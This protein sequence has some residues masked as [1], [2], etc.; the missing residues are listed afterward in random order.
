MNKNTL[1]ATLIGTTVTISDGT[2]FEAASQEDASRELHERGYQRVAGWMFGGG[3]SVVASVV[4]NRTPGE[5]FL[6]DAVTR[7]GNGNL[8]KSHT[9]RVDRA[10]TYSI[11][12]YITVTFLLHGNGK[13]FADA[14]MT[15]KPNGQTAEILAIPMEQWVGLYQRLAGK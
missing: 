12:S 4:D 15:Y 6:A 13:S 10:E 14:Y 3:D 7:A 11:T 2:T 9:V 5:K 1:D 8:R